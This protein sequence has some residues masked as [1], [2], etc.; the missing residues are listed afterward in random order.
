MSKKEGK[1]PNRAFRIFVLILG[2]LFVIGLGIFLLCSYV[3]DV[4]T[5][6]VFF[7]IMKFLNLLILK[8]ILISS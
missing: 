7:L 3:F 8:I 6:A 5:K 4:R 2:F 1:K